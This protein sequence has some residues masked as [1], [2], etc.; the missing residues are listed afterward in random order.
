MQHGLSDPVSLHD[1][2]SFFL[3]AL[4]FT[5]FVHTHT[6]SA[7]AQCQSSGVGSSQ[8]S[9][10]RRADLSTHERRT[11]QAQS[12][13]APGSAA[14]ETRLLRQQAVDGDAAEE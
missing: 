14:L 10:L 3:H 8:V 12:H 11:S 6:K 7:F 2:C 5:V 1:S 13:P 4:I 9:G